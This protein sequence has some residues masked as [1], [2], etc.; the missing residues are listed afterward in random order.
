AREVSEAAAPQR[1]VPRLAWAAGLA[2][3]AV[4]SGLIAT[5]Q[6]PPARTVSLE[7]PAIV[8]AGTDAAVRDSAPRIAAPGTVA[9]ARQEVAETRALPASRQEPRETI[10]LARA[11]R[12][13]A[14]EEAPPPPAP[15]A[16]IVLM[17][18]AASPAMEG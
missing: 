12:M 15:A 3:V 2:A 7:S 5:R 6:Q 14:D 13:V 4:M 16:G 17:R 1:G 9:E 10:D 8:E 11:G 18:S